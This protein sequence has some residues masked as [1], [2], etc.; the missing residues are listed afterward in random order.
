MKHRFS[1]NAFTV[2]CLCLPVSAVCGSYAVTLIVSGASFWAVFTGALAGCA[3]ALLLG[4]VLLRF[5]QNSSVQPLHVLEERALSYLDTV[6][7]QPPAPLADRDL[8][9]LDQIIYE[10]ARRGNLSAQILRQEKDKIHHILESSQDG[11]LIL[12]ADGKIVQINQAA[13]AFFRREYNAGYY[14]SNYTTSQELLDG[15]A[16]VR[17]TNRKISFELDDDG[18]ILR[19]H[20]LPLELYNPLKEQRE[21]WIAVFIR[22]ITALYKT[23]AMRSE[24]FANV[25]H[26][27]KTPLT[28]L[29]GFG[30]LLS[31]GSVQDEE[32]RRQYE[33]KMLAEAHRMASLIDDILYISKLENKSR[34][35]ETERVDLLQAAKDSAEELA[36]AAEKKHVSVYFYG[37]SA[38]LQAPHGHM[39][40][41]TKNLIENAI[42]YNR[43][44][45]KVEVTVLDKGEY[46]FFRVSDTG[47]GIP[48][49]HQGRIFERFYRVD[50]GRSRSLGGTGLGLSIVKHIVLNKGGTINLRSDGESGTTIEI[51]LPK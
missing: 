6:P 36:L 48:K 27:L 30:D 20:I 46:V 16:E 15:V 41:L 10:L 39:Q 50:K 44:N 28:A 8:A 23:D 31:S 21:K 3:V 17:E 1:V 25:S 34:P 7:S 33:E 14:L 29:I 13:K 32:T 35:T 19:L 51:T 9:N 18:S 26:E 22:D 11:L 24:F 49:E 40:Q 4:V 5:F 47:I 12:S 45:G 38:V 37:D 2:L 42:L 43:E